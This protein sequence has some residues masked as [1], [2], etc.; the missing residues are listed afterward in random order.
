[1]ACIA[2]LMCVPGISP[3]YGQVTTPTAKP[4]AKKARTKLPAKKPAAHPS[5]AAAE[6]AAKTEK[7]LSD[8]T[9]GLEGKAA[10]ANELKL[11]AFARQHG[12]DEYGERADL[13]IGHY[14]LDKSHAPAAAASFEAAL[15]KPFI[16][17]EYAAYWHAQAL[18]QTGRNDVAL[19]ELDTFRHTYPD[20]V[21][22]D[23][24]AQ[25][26]AE[27]AIAVGNPDQAAAALDAYPK[28]P[29][30]PFLLLLRAQAREKSGKLV[31]AA[32][33]Y[34]AIYYGFPLSDEAHVAGA[35]IPGLSQ[36]LGQSFPA[37]P[38]A[39]QIARAEALYDAHRW[40]EA[41][42]E[43]EALTGQTAG[44]EKQH[45]QLRVAECRAGQG[46][47]P[48]AFA[49][50][51]F[52][53]ADTDAERLYFLSQEYRSQKLE[54]EML[55]AV[56]QLAA[57][58]PQN[59][60]AEEAFFATGNYYW[61]NLDRDHAASY[62]QRTADFAAEKN[63]PVAAWRATWV[64]YLDRKPDAVAQLETYIE[65]FPNSGY[66]QDAL[67]WL[68]RSAERENAA[69]RAR[70]FYVKD[71]QRF[72]QTYF[73]LQAADRLKE[74]GDGPLEP[75][76]VLAAIPDA[77][78]VGAIDGPIPV[79][80][81]DNWARAQA[82][83]SIAFD[84]SAELELRA[85]YAATQSPRLL[86]E[87]A[88]SAIDAQNYAVGIT[89]ARVA[90]PQPEARKPAEMTSE[91]ASALYP[92][93]YL[94]LVA[95]AATRNKVDPMLVAGIMR[96]ESAFASEAV[97]YAGAVGL[98][99]VL[100]KTAPHLAHRMKL[101]Y[102]RARLFDPE[103]NL[104]LGT[105]Y[106]NDLLTQFGSPEAALAAYNAGEDRVIAWEGERKYSETPEFVESIPFSQTRDYVQIVLRN[107][108]MYRLLSLNSSHPSAA[109]HHA[110]AASHPKTSKKASTR[111]AL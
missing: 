87:A 110:P 45:M 63:A 57:R 89:L 64:A 111:G 33:D 103:Y 61:V 47:G 51:G 70:G 46:A 15:K 9:H 60:W 6:A 79:A 17:T 106:L 44:A 25:S 98:M 27:A 99:Q 109:I 104:D 14:Q 26:Y 19:G 58:Y 34:L 81:A 83:R 101:R 39:Q 84:A 32:N 18:R 102:T 40:Y 86:L 20:S 95:R 97:S 105:L 1:V 21:M 48:S 80:A 54:P 4:P 65:K 76:D 66:L 2:L 71:V 23:Q 53:D 90:Y 52:S 29:Q 107:A 10:P 56:N 43:F 93:P 35:R 31:P 69:P 13:A 55:D 50:L 74:L 78:L 100:P 96:Q 36:Q 67:Y 7:L 12:S 62:Y 41:R 85:G 30:K 75:A 5:A 49:S 94:P 3:V 37:T 8:L 72:P 92:L 91:E 59:H 42:T 108:A 22:V 38:L 82:L 11:E 68:G 28:T 77:P 88:L 24:A 16:L 73:G